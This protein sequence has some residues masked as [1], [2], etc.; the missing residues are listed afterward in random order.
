LKI[1]RIDV[2]NFLD[3]HSSSLIKYRLHLKLFLVFIPLLIFGKLV[4]DVWDDE[5]FDWD[6]PP[7]YSVRDPGS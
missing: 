4:E 2:R 7:F 1:N 3:L 5:G 6:I